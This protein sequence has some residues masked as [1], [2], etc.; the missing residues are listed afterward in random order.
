MSIKAS[1]FLTGLLFGGLAAGSA[2][3]LTAPKSGKE[4]R[5][6][7][8]GRGRE[9]SGMVRQVIN[10]SIALK[11]DID[12]ASRRS[13]IA[14]KQG[15]K[16]IRLSID[17]WKKSTEPSLDELRERIQQLNDQMDQLEEST[18]KEPSS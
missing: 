5:E 2:V 7:W 9:I 10:D 18:K 16:G 1:S 14:V 3:L 12:I 13:A 11:N 17:D 6:E 15:V 8:S 4:T